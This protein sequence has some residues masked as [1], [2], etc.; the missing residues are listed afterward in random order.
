MQKN[1]VNVIFI[2]AI[3]LLVS[4]SSLVIA[5]LDEK[6][7]NLSLNF[8]PP[9]EPVRNV[10]EFER[11]EGVLIR[12]PFGIS[13]QIIAEMAE[14]VEVTT[15]VASE[16]EK[17]HV[18]SQYQSHGV[19]LGHCAF[20]IAPSNSYWTRDYGPWFVFNG[21]D[22]LGVVDFTYNRPRPNDN[23]IPSAYAADQGF[24]TYLMPL[25][26][27]GGNY[28]TDGNGISVSTTLVWTENN[29][30]S[31]GEIEEIVYEYLGIENYHV[32][33]DALGEYIQHIDC[34]AKFLSPDT[35]MIIEVSQG[36]SQYDE[37]EEAVQYF[38]NQTS[39]YGY[40]YNVERVYAP[41]G[42]AYI[43]CLVLNDKVLVPV[44]GS[45]WD[46]EAVLS[47]Q[48]AMP[49]YEVLTFTGSWQSTDALHCRTKG[50][51]DREMLYIEHTPLTG[52]QNGTNG[53]EIQTKIIAYSG[54][55]IVDDSTVV[56]WREDGGSWNTD[57]LTAIGNDYYKANIYPE[58]NGA[59]IDYYIKAHDESDRVEYHPF[60]GEPDP[61]SFIVEIVST[62][63]PPEIPET[64]IGED[65]GEVGISYIYSSS[66]NDSNGDQVYYQ[67]NWG[68]GSYSDWLG[69]YESDEIVETNHTWDEKGTYSVRVKAKDTS[70]DQSDWSEPLEVTMPKDKFRFVTFSTFLKNFL[71]NIHTLITSIFQISKG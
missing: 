27:A 34:W 68:D 15:I 66:T 41:N 23:A 65:S 63:N 42:E 31:H 70:G 7:N 61:H 11:M 10:A 35:I 58:E 20:L 36:H 64:P 37:L 38:E 33:S 9:P 19:N 28:M 32:V 4:S 44:S 39:C 48:N 49:G 30:Y 52:I 62:N 50:I 2:S 24:P 53:I 13:Y 71:N 59:T 26:H 56:Y 45:Q 29:G 57:E 46:D 67:W 60:I 14:D 18:I 6:E 12:Y 16:S 47:F 40:P 17:N 25:E 51:P 69:P 3:L 54:E 55:D 5:Q 21:D 22:E 8:S 43:N 1:R